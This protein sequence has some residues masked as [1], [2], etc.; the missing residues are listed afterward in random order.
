MKQAAPDRGALTFTS[1]GMT[2]VNITNDPFIALIPSMINLLSEGD[3]LISNLIIA[4]GIDLTVPSFFQ[5]PYVVSI[6]DNVNKNNFTSGSS[7]NGNLVTSIYNIPY[8]S[9]EG[10]KIITFTTFYDTVKDLLTYQIPRELSY[11]SVNQATVYASNKDSKSVINYLEIPQSFYLSG[12]NL[13]VEILSFSI[14]F[15]ETSD[16][17]KLF[18]SKSNIKGDAGQPPPVGGGTYVA[19]WFWRND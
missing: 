12:S 13:G 9:L 7:T 15:S 5:L 2:K 11:N 1:T 16:K 17:K 18:S 8:Q 4:E 6:I 3:S 14:N 19:G 10:E